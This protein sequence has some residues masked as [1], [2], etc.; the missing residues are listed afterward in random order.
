M[1]DLEKAGRFFA[2]E[3]ISNREL[4]DAVLAPVEAERLV[5][6]GIS[7]RELKA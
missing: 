5:G 4:K 2:E 1:Y 7:N 3:S 6:G